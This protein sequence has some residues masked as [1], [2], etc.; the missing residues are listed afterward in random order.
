MEEMF[1]PEYMSDTTLI[2]RLGISLLTVQLVSCMGVKLLRGRTQQEQI[3]IVI[4]Y[5]KGWLAWRGLDFG[6][7]GGSSGS[8]R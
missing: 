3:H 7:G 1:V 5:D 6:K 4:A 8:L 2:C